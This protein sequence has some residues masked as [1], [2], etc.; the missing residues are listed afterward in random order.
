[1]SA[2]GWY[3]DPASSDGQYRYWDGSAWTNE[4]YGGGQRTRGTRTWVWFAVGLAVVAVVVAILVMRPGVIP[5]TAV[6]EDR[7]SARPT[8]SQWNELPPTETP[9]NPDDPGDGQLVE[10]PSNSDEMRSDV[11]WGRISGG[12]L[13]FEARDWD[14]GYVYIPWLYDHNSQTRSIA[15][16]WMSNISVGVARYDEGFVDPRVTAQQMMDCLASSDLY[17]GFTGREDLRDEAFQLDG[18]QGWRITADV[19]VDN[20]GDIKGDV[21]DVVVLDTGR[22]DGL[23]VYIS[24]AT[25]DHEENLAE[26]A[27][28]FESLRV[29]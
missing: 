15:P 17:W 25:I 28:A 11:D 23:S 24:C 27:E 14:G 3:P 8:G 18:R 7:N 20:Q 19:F 26:V 6:P 12:G 5:G 29:E 21:V 2:P 13:S 4:V 22:D 1:M 10:C 9:S 16:G